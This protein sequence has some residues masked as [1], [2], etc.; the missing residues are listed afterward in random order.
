MKADTLTPQNL[1][2]QTVRYVVPLFQRPYVW[3]REDQW[4][5]LWQDIRSVAERLEEAQGMHEVPPHFLGAIVLDHEPTGT[6]FIQVRRVIDGQQRLTTLQLLLDATQVV[7]EAHGHNTDSQALQLLVLNQAALAHEPIEVFKVWPTD[8]DQ[9]VFQATMDNDTVVPAELVAE[10]IAAAHA[11]FVDEITRWSGAGLAAPERVRDRLHTLTMALHSRLKM[12]VI[13]LEPG[14]NAQV[15]FE[16]LNHRGSPLLAAD[17]MKNLVFQRAVQQGLT[18]LP[19]YQQYW[20]HVDGKYWRTKVARGRQY[21]PRID[22]FANYWLVM[23]LAREIPSDRIFA[24]FRERVA[25]QDSDVAALLKEFSADANVFAGWENLPADSV[26]RVFRYRILQAMDTGVVSPIFLW[27]TRWPDTVLPIEQRDKALK[28][29]ESWLVR[30]MLCR[31]TA[32]DLNRTLLDLLQ[33]LKAQP[34]ANAGD[35]TTEFLTRQTAESRY[36]PSDEAVRQ[37]LVGEPLYRALLRARL[38]MVL[39]GLEDDMRTSMSEAPCPQNLTVEHI[40]PQA[41]RDHWNAANLDPTAALLRD[42]LIHTLGN[43]TLVNPKLNSHLSNHPWTK[44]EAAQRNLKDGGKYDKLL[45]N[46]TIKL[47]AELLQHHLTE[48]TEDD[49]RHRTASMTERILRIWPRPQTHLPQPAGDVV[50]EP[51]DKAEADQPQ[52]PSFATLTEWLSAQQQTELPMH[53]TDIED[54]LGAELPTE[55]RTVYDF[56]KTDNDI[57]TAMKTAG[58]KATGVSLAEERVTLVLDHP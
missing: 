50:A 49:I 40:M 46:T 47:N 16:T 56:W 24:E 3:N 12:V 57:G 55:A 6:A 53:F 5:P 52:P 15:I 13:D 21:V 32:K 27:L 42:Q 10:P 25:T 23:R 58:Y 7:V 8:R 33:E 18:P 4:E 54:I 20:K 29:L 17:L 22:I 2:G 39:E 34:V 14:D 51:A 11:F 19:L 31:L 30:R 48:W 9:A 43:L 28:A 44:E 45:A 38:R 36:W 41:W 1:F 37:R 26:P 35:V